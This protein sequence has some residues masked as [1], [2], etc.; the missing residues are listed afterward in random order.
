MPVCG[1]ADNVVVKSVG[2][3]RMEEGLYNHVDM[4]LLLDIADLDRGS[5]VAGA[6]L[7]LPGRKLAASGGEPC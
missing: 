4:V 7:G 1:Q 5:R 2:T 6:G 3:K